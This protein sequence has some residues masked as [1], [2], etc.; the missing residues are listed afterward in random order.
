M[1]T[2]VVHN[3]FQGQQLACMSLHIDRREHLLQRLG[4]ERKRKRR[5]KGKEGTFNLNVDLCGEFGKRGW[6]RDRRRGGGGGE[7]SSTAIC[8][9]WER[10]EQGPRHEPEEPIRWQMLLR[11]RRRANAPSILNAKGPIIY[12]YVCGRPIYN[13]Y[14]GLYKNFKPSHTKK[15]SPLIFNIYSKT[16]DGGGGEERRGGVRGVGVRRKGIKWW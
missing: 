8:M 4:E 10:S 9:A 13:L 12:L 16:N 15:Y 5:N 6:R 3:M 2:K 7:R 1:H 14:R 11:C